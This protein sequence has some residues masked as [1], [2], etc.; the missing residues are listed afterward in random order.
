MGRKAKAMYERSVDRA[1]RLKQNQ[2][3]KEA[4][5]RLEDQRAQNDLKRCHDRDL[6]MLAH[7]EDLRRDMEKRDKEQAERKAAAMEERKEKEA[8]EQERIAAENKV[9]A[10]LEQK[11]NKQIVKREGDREQRNQAYIERVRNLKTAE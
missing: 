2:E 11:R 6:A 4:D 5:E 3:K 1:K 10:D 8:K 9:K 7:V